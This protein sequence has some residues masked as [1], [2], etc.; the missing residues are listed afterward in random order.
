MEN[1]S[2]LEKAILR[3]TEDIG[4]ISYDCT[5]MRDAAD[6]SDSCSAA[7][8]SDDN[9]GSE[10]GRQ[11]GLVD[12]SC[13]NVLGAAIA[14]G[15]SYQALAEHLTDHFSLA[16]PNFGGAS[17]CH[18]PAAA[19]KQTAA[20]FLYEIKDSTFLFTDSSVL[21]ATG[22]MALVAP[23]LN[24]SK[25]CRLPFPGS[26]TVAE[27]ARLHLA[28]DLIAAIPHGPVTVLCDSR[29]ALQLLSRPHDNVTSTSLL[30]ALLQIGGCGPPDHTALGAG[31]LL[32]DGNDLADGLAKSAHTEGSRYH[33][34]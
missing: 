10:D 16:S 25:T 30:K 26:S 2:E 19:L 18:T 7:S 29:P 32:I 27:L 11:R 6:G 15:V 17:K 1:L 9:D 23:H 8:M 33:L 3:R 22:Q 21:L 4:S 14:W 5:P 28:A 24:A 13:Q 20:A 31:P 12:T 34:R